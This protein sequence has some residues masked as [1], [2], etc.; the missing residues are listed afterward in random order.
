MCWFIRTKPASMLSDECYQNA[1]F[2]RRRKSRIEKVGVLLCFGFFIFDSVN[3]M[4]VC[5]RSFVSFRSNKKNEK[6]RKSNSCHSKAVCLLN[7][8]P[9]L[10]KHC[11]SSPCSLF[12]FVFC[13]QN[14]LISLYAFCNIVFC[15]TIFSTSK[16]G[17]DSTKN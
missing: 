13:T 16:N 5:F 2:E 4:L 1:R 10:R 7:W 17:I 12:Q 11:P 3:P 15:K 14:D 9:D 6:K 8:W